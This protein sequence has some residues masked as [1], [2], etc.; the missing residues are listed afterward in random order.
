MRKTKRVFLRHTQWRDLRKRLGSGWNDEEFLERQLVSGV[1]TTVDN[2]EAWN[3]QSFRNGVSG[4]IGIMLPQWNTL[5]RSTS[6][7]SR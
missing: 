2:V 7:G 6:L 4:N 3:G 1:L 5:G